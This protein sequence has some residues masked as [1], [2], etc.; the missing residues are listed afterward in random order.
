MP[1]VGVS[2]R[3]EVRCRLGRL[4]GVCFT[5]ALTLFCYGVYLSHF[6][7][8]LLSSGPSGTGAACLVVVTLA[9]VGLVTS[10]L[11]TASTHPGRVPAFFDAGSLNSRTEEAFTQLC[12]T[13]E[14]PTDAT[15]EM[16]TRLRVGITSVSLVS[17]L[18]YCEACDAYK[19][20]TTHH[21]STCGVCVFELDHHC[22]WV[23]GCVGR[24]NHK[25]FLLF[26]FY[27]VICGAIVVATSAYA[28]LGSE[29]IKNTLLFIAWIVALAFV[30]ILTPFLMSSAQTVQQNSSTIAKLQLRRVGPLG[31]RLNSA[32]SRSKTQGQLPPHNY[33]AVRAEESASAT[34]DVV[35]DAKPAPRGLHRIM[36]SQPKFP[37]WVL[38]V[39]PD[40]FDDEDRWASEIK[41]EVEDQVEY[42]MSTMVQLHARKQQH[43]ASGPPL[44]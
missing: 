4:F 1:A 28:V 14:L 44:L 34:V 2:R 26:L 8:P 22:P 5:L 11:R 23:G 10:F 32:R 35:P 7:V 24:N 38:P 9:Y 33:A 15:E 19:C 17:S 21:C 40:L 20:P 6:V 41:Q 42:H 37:W 13:L 30:L 18:R 39:A 31:S 25:Y 3:Q 29:G 36:G 12:T 16:R 43:A 27:T